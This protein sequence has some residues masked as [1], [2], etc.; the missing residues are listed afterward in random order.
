MALVHADRVMES[1]TTTGTGTLT[2]AGA[3]AGARTF[4]AGVGNANTCYYAIEAVD[5]DGV[6]TGDWEVGLGTV[7][8]G[9][10]A[11]TSVLASSNAGAAVNLAA[12]T[13]RVF[14]VTPAALV[15]L[16]ARTDTAN[17]FTAGPQVLV[18]GATVRQSGGVAGTDEVR[19]THDGDRGVV[20]S[21][22]G[23][24]RCVGAGAGTLWE[25]SRPSDGLALL[26]VLA[27]NSVRVESRVED[28]AGASYMLDAVGEVR[29]A[30][31]TVITWTSG[32]TSTGPINVGVAK[33]G[34][35]ALGVT[36]GSTGG[37]ALELRQV[38]SGGTPGANAARLYAKDVAGTAE[39]FVKD[40]AGNETQIS[41]HATDAP[42]H[43]YDLADEFPFVTKEVNHYTGRVRYVNHS[44][45][46]RA[47]QALFNGTRTLAQIQAMPADER[48]VVL[49][50]TFDQH[51]ARLGLTGPAAPAVR[52]WSGD[53]AERQAEYDAARARDLLLHAAW[54]EYDAA[55]DAELAAHAAWESLP[56]AERG[57][58]P[59]VRF[60]RAEPRV[61]PAADVRKPVP[62]WLAAR[63]VT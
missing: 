44:R 19:V 30:A 14:A 52:S 48:R 33:A 27:D 43:F 39:V 10:L 16:F 9:T 56:P 58:E 5:G 53:Q 29:L 47:M 59:P 23:P 45:Q 12:G 37:A 22:D 24:V 57:P 46:A 35:N 13:K 40:E 60:E 18:G 34:S 15:T 62:P 41:P 42:A 20:Q 2:L 61:R 8:A 17:T 25:A 7:G 31:A 32:G 55:R 51:N 11:R 36:D 4:A 54:V 3:V 1:T 49:V 28:A 50:E 21:M 6:P 63:G 26:K 38:A